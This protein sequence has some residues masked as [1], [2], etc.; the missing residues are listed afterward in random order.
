[1][2][3]CVR[4]KSW[5]AEDE[6]FLENY[7]LEH[8]YWNLSIVPFYPTVLLLLALRKAKKKKRKEENEKRNCNL[9]L[10]TQ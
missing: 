8:L 2:S 6:T 4:T 1:M 5:A 9:P 10:Y 3:A 7:A